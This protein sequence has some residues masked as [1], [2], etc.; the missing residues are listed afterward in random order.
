MS[1]TRHLAL[2]ACLA[3]LAVPAGASAHHTWHGP[4][5]HIAAAVPNDPG[6]GKTPAGWRGVQWNFAGEW[7]VNAQGAWDNLAAVGRP[8]GMGTVVAVL[9]T[10]VA[11]ANRGKFKRSPDFRKGQFV[12]GY[13]F[14]GHDPYAD[15]PNGH[16]THVA[17]TIA[18]ATNNGI[19]LTG[20]AFGARIMPVRVLDANGEGDPGTISRGVRWAA[21]HGADVINLSLEF[22]REVTAAS[23]PS[24]IKAIRYAHNKRVVVV[25]ASGNE[26]GGTV[27]YPAR[28]SYVIS[29]GATTE[30]GCLAAYSNQGRGLDVSA[31]GGG[32][33]TDITGE[34]Q[35]KPDETPG[36]EIAQVSYP[37]YCCKFGLRREEGTSMSAPHVS[38]IAALVIASGVIGKNPSPTAVANRIEATSRDLG[39]PGYD[40]LYGWGLVDA[41]AAT[42]P[43]GPTTPPPGQ[44]A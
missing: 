32:S 31:P 10:G 33:D 14:V 6:K 13:D 30:N 11:Y 23:I 43:G 44:G 36:R 19:G 15:D 37:D 8:G 17:G 34:A 41:G 18:E 16:G 5:A 12:R 26:A 35:C 25:G 22:G 1:R 20:L 39:A 2:A 29:V 9:D 27:A 4:I 42:T 40:E 3:A 28:A 21:D 7:G 38:A 24:L